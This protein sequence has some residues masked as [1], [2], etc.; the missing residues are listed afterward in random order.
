[1]F[2]LMATNID[3]SNSLMLAMVLIMA[4]LSF[5]SC[6]AYCV[7][8]MI[9]RMVLVGSGDGKSVPNGGMD[10]SGSRFWYRGSILER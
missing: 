8:C 4:D 10:I 7:F 5:E 6:I 3:A 9:I 2:G 1:M